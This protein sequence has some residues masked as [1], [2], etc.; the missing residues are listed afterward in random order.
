[1]AKPVQPRKHLSTFLARD[2][3]A[4]AVELA[5]ILFF[6]TILVLGTF[7]LPRMLLLKQKMER[8]AS[9]MADLIAQIDPADGNVQAQIDDLMNAAGNL[10]SPYTLE[11]GGRVIITSVGNPSGTQEMIMWQ[12]QN[13]LGIPAVSKIGIAGTEP[14]LPGTLVVRAGEN[15]IIA[16]V[17]Y[18]YAPL[19]GSMFYEE[20]TLYSRAFTRPR[21]SNLTTPPS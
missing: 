5:C 3:G 14:D 12:Q 20:R 8:S 21:F 10:M 13:D 2:D 16:E 1:M 17:V 7:E 11:E 9:T 18:H 15:I 6:L 4:V 19:F